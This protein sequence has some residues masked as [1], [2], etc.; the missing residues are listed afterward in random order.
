[1]EKYKT[2]IIKRAKLW[3]VHTKKL[4][5]LENKKRKK[6]ENIRQYIDILFDDMHERFETWRRWS[7]IEAMAM[8]AFLISV[9]VLSSAWAVILGFNLWFIIL[10]TKHHW[11]EKP[12][13][14]T[15]GELDG[16]F[17]TLELLGLIELPKPSGKKD[18]KNKR[19]LFE[20]V[21]ETWGRLKQGVPQLSPQLSMTKYGDI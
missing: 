19:A 18:K 4:V 17:K 14:K 3:L 13:D 16:C 1:M 10:I 15:F 21:K 12:L 20:Q 7:K 9:I 11:V 6:P 5:G 8:L 2:I